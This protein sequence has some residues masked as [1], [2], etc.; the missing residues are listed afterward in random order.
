VSIDVRA[1]KSGAYEV[2]VNVGSLSSDA[3][4]LL[5]VTQASAR[6][7]VPRGENAGR[8]LE[9]TAIVRELRPPVSVGAQGGTGS[10]LVHAPRLRR[11]DDV[12]DKDIRL[13]AFVQRRDDRAILGSQTRALLP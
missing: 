5:A 9:H 6:V 8:T 3:Q 2:S 4:I 10:F 1:V 7:S 13:V 11:I 12:D